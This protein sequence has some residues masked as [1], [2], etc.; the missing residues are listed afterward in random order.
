MIIIMYLFGE[1]CTLG[2][3]GGTLGWRG[4]T[5]GWQGGTFGGGGRSMNN[6]NEAGMGKKKILKRLKHAWHVCMQLKG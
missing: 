4:G 6:Q 2:W 5:L 3:Q 1:G